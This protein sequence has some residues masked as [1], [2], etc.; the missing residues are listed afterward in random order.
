MP[1]DIILPTVTNTKN[2]IDDI[3]TRQWY[4]FTYKDIDCKIE[5]E[6]VAILQYQYATDTYTL[7]TID[8]DNNLSIWS[9]IHVYSD[10]Y[11]FEFSIDPLPAGTKF[12]VTVKD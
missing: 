1:V 10:R 6:G 11:K 9:N 12:V 2:T 5:L 3:S 4:T 8:Q 7:I